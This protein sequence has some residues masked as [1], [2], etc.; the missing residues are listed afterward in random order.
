MRSLHCNKITKHASALRNGQRS[1]HASTIAST[2]CYPPGVNNRVFET[3]TLCPQTVTNADAT[4]SSQHLLRTSSLVV[5]LLSHM[6][7][8]PNQ[9]IWS[10]SA[11]K[12]SLSGGRLDRKKHN[13]QPGKRDD[14]CFNARTGLRTTDTWQSIRRY[15]SPNLCK[16]SP[17][18]QQTRDLKGAE[19]NNA[20]MRPCWCTHP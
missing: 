18:G 12:S 13:R 2:V 16:D 8:A 17:F 4:T 15:T 10:K 19:C 14:N 1:S 9:R 3:A 7:V 5:D 20:A 11:V 6:C